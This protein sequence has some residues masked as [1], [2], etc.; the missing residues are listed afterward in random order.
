MSVASFAGAPPGAFGL[1]APIEADFLNRPGLVWYVLVAHWTECPDDDHPSLGSLVTRAVAMGTQACSR[2]IRRGLSDLAAIGRLAI[3]PDPTHPVGRKIRPLVALPR[4][5]TVLSPPD[6]FGPD[7]SVHSYVL[8]E[9][10]ESLH[11]VREE[12]GGGDNSVLPPGASLTAALGRLET[13]PLAIEACV[14]R[15]VQEYDQVGGKDF[16]PFYRT[17]CRAVVERRLAIGELI[18]AAEEA[19]RPGVKHRGKAFIA[20][21][22]RRMAAV[23]RR[24]YSPPPAPEAEPAPN[25]VESVSRQPTHADPEPTPEPVPAPSTSVDR[26]AA[27]KARWEAMPETDRETIRAEVKAENPGLGRW[28]NM[29]EPLCLAKL[30]NGAP[31]AT[32]PNVIPSTT[33]ILPT[34]RELADREGPLVALAKSA[35]RPGEWAGLFLKAFACDRLRQLGR[36]D[37]FE[38]V[39]WE[40]EPAGKPSKGLPAGQAT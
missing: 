9:G 26:D 25:P 20:A 6:S 11:V 40:K 36:P 37:V 22:K 32:V 17:V 28:K 19:D 33:E 24:R 27:L 12:I 34:D 38:G 30:D 21:V 8:R 29:L 16:S 13:D 7:R 31:L 4:G 5:G 1:A 15:L 23:D 14:S 3:E 10:I 39:P 2:T 35:P 18:F